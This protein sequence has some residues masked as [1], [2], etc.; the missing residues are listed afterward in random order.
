VTATSPG[1]LEE[2]ALPRTITIDDHAGYA[3][4]VEVA[5][6][7]VVYVSLSPAGPGSDA[8]PDSLLDQLGQ[9]GEQV[10]HLAKVGGDTPALTAA[11]V[12]IED[13][14]EPVEDP[15]AAGLTL[16]EFVRQLDRLGGNVSATAR[17][18]G[19]TR[20]K[21]ARLVDNARAEG[22]LPAASRRRRR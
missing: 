18:L 5:S 12:A 3:L 2:P 20:V 7:G 17:H 10:R 6:A 8:L 4:T 22:L 9:I 15:P 21:A 1:R 14:G 13:E 11:P 16:A 19:I